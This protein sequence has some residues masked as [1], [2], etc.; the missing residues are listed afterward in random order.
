MREY[1]TKLD[2]I[3]NETGLI[4]VEQPH[5]TRAYDYGERKA[6]KLKVDGEW[7]H[8][9]IML[10]AMTMNMLKTMVDNLSEKNRDTF[11]SW[12]WCSMGEKGWECVGACS[13]KASA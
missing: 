12:S 4:L 7:V 2:L 3:R 11:L 1:E 6:K 13:K 9:L 10:D 5:G 8:D